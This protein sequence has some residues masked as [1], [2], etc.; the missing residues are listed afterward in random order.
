MAHW[1]VAYALGPFYN[2]AWREL[3]EREAAAAIGLARDTSAGR[4]PSR[5]TPRGWK[6]G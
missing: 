5:Q 4:A 1:G 2:L 6:I 3:G